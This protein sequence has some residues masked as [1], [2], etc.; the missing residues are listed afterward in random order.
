REGRGIGYVGGVRALLVSLVLL[1]GVGVVGCGGSSGEAGHPRTTARTPATNL[2]YPPPRPIRPVPIV[3]V[4]RAGRQ[5]G[6]VGFARRVEA[7]VYGVH[8]FS[9]AFAR[10]TRASVV[11]PGEALRFSVS[12]GSVTELSVAPVAYRPLKQFKTGW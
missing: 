8:V 6:I 5:R 4:S 2:M 3:L 1:V 11:R 9:G 10:P 7:P 12:G